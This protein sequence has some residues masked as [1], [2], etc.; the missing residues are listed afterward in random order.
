MRVKHHAVVAALVFAAA[1]EP[2]TGGST[3]G[4]SG[5]GGTGA[6]THL[7]FRVPPT[8]T[9]ANEAIS[10]AVQVAAVKSD[11]SI[12]PTYI[13][14]VSVAIGTNP[15]SGGLGGTRTVPAVAGVATFSTLYI[16]TA[17]TGYTLVATSS[18]LSSATSGSFNI[19]P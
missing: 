12:D 3:I 6:A 1:C 16:T 10:P 13:L 4:M 19:T 17:G 14:N 2:G 11:G 15:A 7:V 9:I 5:F 8:S 18:T